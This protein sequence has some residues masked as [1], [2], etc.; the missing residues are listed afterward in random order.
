M[1]EN[2]RDM[3]WDV[4]QGIE[5]VTHSDLLALWPRSLTPKMNGDVGVSEQ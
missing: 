4:T 1:Q 3:F 5:M 2:M